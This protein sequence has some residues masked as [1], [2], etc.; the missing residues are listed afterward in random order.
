LASVLI[1]IKL[2]WKRKLANFVLVIQILLSIIMLAQ[3]FVAIEDYRDNLRAV[4]ELPVNNTVVLSIFDYYDTEY[5]TQQVLSSPQVESVGRVYMGDIVFCNNVSCN[6]AAYNEGIISRYSPELQSGSWLSDYSSFSGNAIPAVV[7]SDMKLKVGDVTD[8]SLSDGQTRKITVIGILKEPTQYLY[9]WGSASPEYFTASSVISQKP[10]IIVRYT[11][12][13]ET[14]VFE[15]P[16][17]VPITTSIFI[18]LKSDAADTNMDTFRTE[19]NKYGEITPMQSLVSTFNTNTNTMI[20]G[21]TIMFVVFL[22]LAATGVLSNNVIQSL[23]NRRQFTV[24]YLLG[25]DWKKG[26]AVEVCR[27]GILV[28][29]TMALSLIAGKLGLLMLEWMTPARAFLFYGLVFL[30]IVVMF[31]AVGA[32]FMIKLMREDLSGLLKDLQQ[33]E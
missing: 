21:T 20:G 19:W 16:M 12:F 9:P 5:V 1:A 13:G 10:V 27:V 30:Y 15:T 29:F 33:G 4:N 24:Y 31:T 11:D 26:A 6:L 8:V 17:D 14:S 18:F 23:R 22:L 25:M 2:L 3:V 28:I 7:S 32:G